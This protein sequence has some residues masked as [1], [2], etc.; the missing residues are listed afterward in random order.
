MTS[1]FDDVGTMSETVRHYSFSEKDDWRTPP[2]II[3]GIEDA[4]GG[5][6]IDPCPHE[7]TSHGT[8]NLRLSAG[9]DG[10]EEDWGE[11][12][13][14]ADPVAF[15]NPPFSCKTEWLAKVVEEVNNG[16][17]T[18][19]VITPDGTDTVS[20][21][22]GYIAEHAEYVCFHESRVSYLDDDGQDVGS[23]PFGTAISV[24]G[25]C[26]NALVEQLREWGHVVQ[27]V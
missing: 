19:V 13:P 21:W 7:A 4:L 1:V 3:E 12:T 16:V 2:K 17:A 9:Q 10:L 11:C 25:E 23:P 27:T 20:W 5:I 26:P 8:V 6:D 22:H 18:A 15:V 24:F 14:V